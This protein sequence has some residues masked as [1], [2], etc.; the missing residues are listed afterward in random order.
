MLTAK[1]SA[2]AVSVAGVALGLG[3]DVPVVGVLG[4]GVLIAGFVATVS[5]VYAL[6]VGT[7]ATDVLV[8]SVLVKGSLRGD[9]CV[10]GATTGS[11]GAGVMDG[12]ATGVLE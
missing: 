12:V 1:P 9:K 5:M 10:V 2:A 11:M 4:E 6:A 3:S 7:S 8:G